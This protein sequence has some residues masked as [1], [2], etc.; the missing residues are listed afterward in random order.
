MGGQK[1]YLAGLLFG[2]IGCAFLYGAEQKG[3]YEKEVRAFEESDRTNAPPKGAVLFVGSST[4][5]FWTNLAKDFP[6]WKTIRRGLSGAEVSDMIEYAERIV[7]PYAPEKIVFY[8]GDNDI[9][10]KK[11]PQ[12]VL[13]D[14]KT[15]V[16]KVRAALPEAEI[17][18]LSVKP[19]PSREHLQA[20]G[21]EANRLVKEY[22]E[23]KPKVNYIEVGK[24]LLD[25]NG[26]PD[27]K[28]FKADKLH[29]NEK[30]YEL[31]VKEITRSMGKKAGGHS[32]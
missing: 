19:S 10:R 1:Q 6:E 30:G 7:I 8:A 2:L 13:A 5:T 9:A 32:K 29:M 22:A 25:E 24:L 26:K 12:E 16:G 21:E 4:I 27:P 11:T 31:W 17:D 18:F 28:Y 3:R 20:H 23:S 15:F 14:F